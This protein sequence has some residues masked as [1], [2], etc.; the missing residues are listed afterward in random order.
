MA[1]VLR[2]RAIS[3]E[4][5]PAE[6][7]QRVVIERLSP[8]IDCGRF[9][10]KRTIGEP[11]V[12]EADIFAD[13]HDAVSA[14]LRFRHLR[15]PD[16]DEAP[17]TLVENDRWRGTFTVMELGTYEYT[18]LAWVDQYQTWAR[19]LRK[20]LQAEQDVSVD[21]LIGAELIEAAAA[22][23]GEADGELLRSYAARLR[24][25]Q[26]HAELA[27]EPELA[28]L[29]ARYDDRPFASQYQQTL[30]VTVD[31]ERARF[32]T[33]YEMFPRSCAPEPGRHGTFRD[34]EARLPYIAGMGFDVLYLPPIHPIGRTNRKGRNNTLVAGPDDPGSPWAIGAGDGGHDAINP[35]LGTLDDFRRFVERAQQ[36]GIEV[37]L[38][39]A[40]QCSPDHPYVRQ[41]PEWFRRRPDGTVQYAENPPKKYQDI[42]P[43]DFET[44]RW[45][46]LWEELKS[47]VQFW[48]DQGVRIFRVDNPHTKPFRFWEWLI[49]EIKAAHP[50]IIFLSEAFTRP[51]V[52]YHLAKLG[53][54]Q[55]YTYFA[56]RN[57]KWELTQYLT[58]LTRTSVREFFRPNFWP[59]TPDILT[60]YLQHGGRPAFMAR[61]VLAATLSASYGI[62]GP[63]F[64][65]CEHRPL[66][67]GS[68]EYLN[69]EKYEIRVW[70]LDRPDSLKD[71]IARVNRIRRENPALH[72]NANLTFHPVDN[73]QIICYSKS[74]ADRSNVI[75]VVVNLDPYHTQSGW[76]D[77]AL[78][79]LELD[80]HQSFQ[81]H[82]LL[83][84][85]YYLWHGP[86]NYVELNPHVAPA[87]VF[88]VR[89]KVLTERDFDYF[90]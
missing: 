49:G 46:E 38:D 19:D 55:S 32:S 85:A 37:A 56:W 53:F 28:E 40:F 59:N 23:A 8:E 80:P 81:V 70:D 89:R 58:E 21:L 75:L 15:Q 69:S 29:M 1:E 13:G 39:L 66:R 79:A 31:R 68:E 67:P 77:L 87:H 26:E 48:I 22:R 18:V 47:V 16:W 10:I 30:R 50:E 3:A 43:L 35:A 64:E 14:V 73:E 9:A 24:E 27:L 42:Y 17:M 65:L 51:K 57:T 88:K 52:M 61:L 36:L 33:W 83:T 63:A 6:G 84:D 60:E 45:R 72:D 4:Q 34:C 25:G 2:N 54:T 11:V 71:F 82:D 5:F 62:Y 90:A 12:V 78:D 86:R 20:R 74:T 41:H 7:R 76:V 44:E